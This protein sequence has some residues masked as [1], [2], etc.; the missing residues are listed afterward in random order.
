M[1]YAAANFFQDALAQYR[2]QQGLRATS[3]NLG[4]LGQYAG[5]SKSENDERD[6]VALL[7]SQGMLA[8]PLTD[9]LSKLEAALIQQPAQRMT[10]RFDWARFRT[11]Y[12]H[13]A[14]DSR[15]IELMSD[16]A[17]ARGSRSKA[18][19]LRAALAELEPEQQRE[20]LQQ[21]LTASL[22]R[23]LD[24]K[25][26]KLDVSASIDNLGLDSLMLTELQIWIARLLDINVPLIKLLK[27][28]SIATLS[29]ELLAQLA[30]GGAADA[31]ST[32]D[33]SQGLAAF[34]VADLDGVQVLNPWLVRGR[35]HAD[36]PLRL[37]CFH[38]MGV[39]ASL[40]TNFLLNP[41]A[42]FDIV[43]VQTPGR[44][45][46]L[47][48]PVLESVDQLVDQLVPHLLPLFDRP[49]VIWGH[50]YGGIVAV[51][52]IR[53]LRERYQKEPVHF[54]VTGTVAPHLIHLWQKREVMLKT[55]VADNSAEYLISLSRYVDDPEFLKSILPLMRRDYPLL[56]NYRFQ[57]SAPLDCPITAFAARQDDMVYTDEIREWSQQTV[58]GFELIEVDG[59]H[60]FLNRNRDLITATIQGIAAKFTSR[61][62]R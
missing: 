56:M 50:S 51:E 3:I 45:N 41:P 1:N 37:I 7:E 4:L 16:S 18:S 46:R 25:P 60:W 53:R 57:P 36:A 6:V 20:R 14:R 23:I 40:F 38:S 34:T 9:V 27:G 49:V 55:M 58:G 2:Q 44:E 43:A 47:S 21:E 42:G 30:N 12:P 8:M 62:R 39:G 28:P 10:A 5:M 11:A 33:A 52:V 31:V 29:A 59:D 54:L 17:L 13:L 24:A 32:K 35:S 19:S 48:E 15:F 26:E 22:A 61:G